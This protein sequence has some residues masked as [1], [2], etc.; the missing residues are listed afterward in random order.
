[1]VNNFHIE[2]K[3]ITKR[4]EDKLV[5]DNLS[6]SIKNGD[7]ISIMGPSGS[8]KSTLLNI[9]GRLDTFEG[10]YQYNSRSIAGYEAAE[11]RNQHIGFIFQ[12]YYLMPKLKVKDNILIPT[13]YHKGCDMDIKNRI[14]EVAEKLGIE[15]LL[16]EKAETLSGGEKQR[17]SIARA[18]ILEPD[19]LIADEP[20]GALDADNT[21]A[22]MR[23]F[24]EYVSRKHAVIMVTHDKRVADYADSKY[25]LSGGT[26]DERD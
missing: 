6:L 23:I 25:I 12:L 24:R 3:N 7:F 15:A 8:G 2:L 20:T 22:V 26:L 11:F 17:V 9:L 5:L 10:L 14:R 16:D 13:L 4:Y 19:I 18:L 1:M 21:D